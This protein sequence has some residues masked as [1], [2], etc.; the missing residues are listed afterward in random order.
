MSS[1]SFSNESSPAS[2]LNSSKPKLSRA[3]NPK[4]RTGCI[5]CKK[6]RVKCDECRPHCKNCLRMT[7]F[8]EGYAELRPRKTRPAPPEPPQHTWDSKTTVVFS[9]RPHPGLPSGSNQ[10]STQETNEL[11]FQEFVNMVR[12][13][14]FS[15]TSHHEL[16]ETI[17]PQLAFG[18][19]TLRQAAMAIGAICKWNE[20][21]RRGESCPQGLPAIKAEEDKTHYLRALSHYSQSLKWQNETP[22]PIAAVFLSVLLLAFETLRGGRA[23]ALDHVNHGLALLLAI[24]VDDNQQHVDSFAPNPKPILSVVAD[25]YSRLSVQARFVLGGRLGES[26]PLPHF[27]QGLRARRLTTDSFFLLVD[28][29]MPSRVDLHN[30]PASFST[31]DEFET[32][33][34]A[35]EQTAR[36]MNSLIIDNFTTFWSSHPPANECST[37]DG[38][39]Q[40]TGKDERIVEMSEYS[41][42]VSKQLD[43]AFRPLFNSIVTSDVESPT[44]LRALNLRLQCFGARVFDDPLMFA[45]Y[46]RIAEQTPI[47]KEY[48]S[49]AEI[50]IRAARNAPETPAHRLALQNDVSWR[51]SVVAIFCR[52]PL[53]REQSLWMLRD[54]PGYHSLWNIRSLYVL[55]LRNRTVENANALEGTPEEQWLRLMRR[56]YVLEEGG[57]RLIFRYMEKD[58]F[59]GEWG[60]VED[61]VSIGGSM[62]TV[63]WERQPLSVGG[64]LLMTALI[65]P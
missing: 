63:C 49:L 42:R 22:S 29:L 20:Q 48:L 14:C 28:K 24:I 9:S 44:Y 58:L 39:W 50:A 56:E 45:D 43:D 60:L 36:H 40:S 54:Y 65:P 46:G 34:I 21:T 31:L 11:Y 3:S 27:T 38:F 15:A 16:W 19:S 18:S 30:I 32:Y 8:C 55:A 23:A 47:C 17:I 57:D 6:R 12:R 37:V 10:P 4:V 41:R 33:L 25:I 26:R 52:D 62:D 13:P 53:T 51:L 1:I 35:A 61:V 2:S 7:G 64:K 5:T 59:S